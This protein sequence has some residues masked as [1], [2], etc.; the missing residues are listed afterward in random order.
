MFYVI[1]SKNWKCLYSWTLYCEFP[2]HNCNYHRQRAIK[3]NIKMFKCYME[4]FSKVGP[5][6]Y[7]YGI[8]MSPLLLL[9]KL[10]IYLLLARW[11][12]LLSWLALL[13][14]AGLLLV[15]AHWLLSAVAPR[16]QSASSWAFALQYLWPTA[17]IAPRRVESSW[18]GGQAHVP[19]IGRQILTYHTTREAHCYD[20]LNILF[21]KIQ[22][23]AD[24]YS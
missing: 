9:W 19:C 1:L 18:A 3:K 8:V 17:Y 5:H 2:L 24:I 7:S 21:S 15:V 16:M 13:G 23:C 22:I 10:C 11:L 4:I 20:F 14:W 6:F 12:S